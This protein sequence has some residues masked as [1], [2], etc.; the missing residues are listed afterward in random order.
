MKLYE[1]TEESVVCIDN[2]FD[3]P[4]FFDFNFC[5]NEYTTNIF[6]TVCSEETYF[7][8]RRGDTSNVDF[9]SDTDDM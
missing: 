3:C 5:S 2:C 9:T 4:Y 8:S 1:E 6:E 7:S